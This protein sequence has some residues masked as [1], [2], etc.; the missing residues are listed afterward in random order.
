[1]HIICNRC[2]KTLGYNTADTCQIQT[3]IEPAPS[4]VNWLLLTFSILAV[5]AVEYVYGLQLNMP[6]IRS[7][8]VGYQAYLP[9][10]FIDH[11]LTFKTYGARLFNGTIPTWTGIVFTPAEGKYLDKY[12]IGTALLQCPFFFVAD[13][14]ATAFGFERS[15]MSLPYQIANAA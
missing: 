7:D 11:D 10:F 5:A 8:G 9:A 2:K 4:E 14:A 12:P 1:V 13:R 15:G 3:I 6:P